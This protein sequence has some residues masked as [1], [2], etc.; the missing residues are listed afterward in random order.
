MEDTTK[1]KE[2]AP[3]E[4]ESDNSEKVKKLESDS[5]KNNE[6]EQGELANTAEVIVINSPPPSSATNSPP[7]QG[8]TP[9]QGKDHTV[10]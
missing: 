6:V 1:E 7:P 8:T 10:W 9:P 3:V 2:V 4:E 5:H